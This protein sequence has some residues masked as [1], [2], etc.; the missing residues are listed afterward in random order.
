MSA[1]FEVY[2]TKTLLLVQ[3]MVVK[4]H[5]NALAINKKLSLLGYSIDS[6]MRQWK[7][8]LNLAGIYHAYDK[9]QLL[10]I[11]QGSSEYMQ[12]K[13]ASDSGPVLTDF[14]KDLFN[15]PMADPAMVNEYRIGSQFYTNL[16][17][18]YPD[19]RT[20]INGILNPVDVS[21][22]T[23][24]ADGDI[25]FIGDYVRDFN[26]FS[27]RPY[28]RRINPSVFDKETLIEDHE[29]DIIYDIQLFV[30]LFLK[31]WINQ[32]YVKRENL[33]WPA[34][35]GILFSIL[36]NVIANIRLGVAKTNKANT[37]HI[38]S[39]LDS[40]GSL[41]QWVDNL[42]IK[43]S[44]WLY[45]NAEWLTHIRG[46][47]QSLSQI[48]D[49][50]FTPSNVPIYAHLAFHQNER[51]L[52]DLKPE[53]EV[54]S[55]GLNLAVKGVYSTQ[56]L[57]LRD[58]LVKEFPVAK[59]NELDVDT[60]EVDFTNRI[61]SS[62]HSVFNTKMLETKLVD[63]SELVPY[64]IED[65]LMNFWIYSVAKGTY[66]GTAYVTHP[67]TKE[68]LQFTMLNALTLLTY[69][70]NF[71][72][73]ETKLDTIPSY[74][75]RGLPREND[76]L[77]DGFRGRPQKSFFRGLIG[78]DDLSDVNLDLMYGNY[79]PEYSHR[80][81]TEFFEHAS[82]GW[83]ELNRQY[84]L[85]DYSSD[86]KTSSTLKWVAANM[87]W[88]GM[89]INTPLFGESYANWFA[90]MDLN[91]DDLTKEDCLALMLELFLYGTGYKE[92]VNRSM[93]NIQQACL[94]VLSFYSSPT[95]QYVIGLSDYKASHNREPMDKFSDYGSTR[96]VTL[97]VNNV[98]HT[99]TID[100]SS[101]FTSMTIPVA[102]VEEKDYGLSSQHRFLQ[103]TTSS[104]SIKSTLKYAFME[105]P[106]SGITLIS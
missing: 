72:Y 70:Y 20:L 80:N 28:Y 84:R 9:D 81:S 101:I 95:V 64:Q 41:G 37:F 75:V 26:L 53:V 36:P 74:Y 3:S 68:R 100:S 65:V 103:D 55:I 19:Q 92:N 6:D 31:R 85:A 61:T 40:Y 39:Y 7:Y 46:T 32:R 94:A 50:L 52:I 33:Y 13:V 22:S 90:R 104:I 99:T 69:C 16:V 2:R 43:E 30:T 8:Y 12:I 71:G 66:R 78:Q 38:K 76:S 27:N 82:D 54:K 96:D 63:L 67:K 93:R 83:K 34:I 91:P 47:E 45:R 1:A 23:T 5:L 106:I 29:S 18:K 62:G 77:V 15:G 73:F 59:F 98:H 21:I 57:T 86:I 42:A 56:S 10:E 4:H 51:L 24:A 60:D 17:N 105:V 58:A 25:L 89:W 88:D 14:V 48:V 44:L 49:N 97:S 79:Y 11:N 102:V 87:R 35:E